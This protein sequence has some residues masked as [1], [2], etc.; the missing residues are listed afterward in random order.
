MKRIIWTGTLVALAIATAGCSS[1]DDKKK[2]TVDGGGGGTT[3][4]NAAV[5]EDGTFV[6]TFDDTNWQVR[7]VG[8][9][10]LHAVTCVGNTNGWAAGQ[11]GYVAHTPDGGKTWQ[12]QDAH[13][14]KTLRSIHFAYEEGG[15]WD[16]TEKLVGI[17]AGD[18]GALATSQ[19]GG[20]TWS[21]A[22][23]PTTVTLRS[24]VAVLSAKL[25]VAVGDGGML[26]RSAD[27][28]TGW[29]QTNV[30]SAGDLMGVTSTASGNVILAVD[31][32]GA[33]WASK[34]L[35]KTFAVES[36]VRWR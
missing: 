2:K 18:E 33:V 3:G 28:G 19:N 5:G 4:W 10:D 35:G 15:S 9:I 26:I 11:N 31:S 8:Q 30:A 6:E 1:D 36:K 27:L 14:T 7:N 29:E 21:P 24:A 20:K 34:D 32:N 23:V 16:G 17:V 12:P 13:T 25:F 22:G